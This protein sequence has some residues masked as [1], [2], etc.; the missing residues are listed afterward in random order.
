MRLVKRISQFRGWLERCPPLVD[1]YRSRND[2]TTLEFTLA[3][4]APISPAGRSATFTGRVC[5]ISRTRSNTILIIGAIEDGPEHTYMFS[6]ACDPETMSGE[7]AFH[8]ASD[9]ELNDAAL[10]GPFARVA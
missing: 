3:Q 9:P 5:G 7:I 6:A 10:F 8:N 4:P 1:L 2:K